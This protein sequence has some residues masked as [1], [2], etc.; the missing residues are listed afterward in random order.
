MD[1]FTLGT[2]LVQVCN[3]LVL[4][5]WDKHGILNETHFLWQVTQ[6]SGDGRVLNEAVGRTLTRTLE[7]EAFVNATSKSIRGMY[8]TSLFANL[9]I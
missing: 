9:G 5:P 7:L 6:N 2:T 4:T 3:F 1:D 8:C